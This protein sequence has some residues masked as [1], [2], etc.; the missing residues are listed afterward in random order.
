MNSLQDFKLIYEIRHFLI[1]ISSM[2][3]YTNPR[4][5]I[6]DLEFD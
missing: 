4:V 5:L 1:Y 3:Q 6:R 2:S